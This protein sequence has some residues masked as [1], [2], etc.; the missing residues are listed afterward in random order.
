MMMKDKECGKITRVYVAKKKKEEGNARRQ[1]GERVPSVS[2]RESKNGKAK[3][4]AV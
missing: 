1:S 4:L 3:L 2:G